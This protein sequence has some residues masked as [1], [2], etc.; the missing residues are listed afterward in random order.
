MPDEASSSWLR[1]SDAMSDRKS[2]ALSTGKE[3]LTKLRSS[4]VSKESEGNLQ[5]RTTQRADNQNVQLI[6]GWT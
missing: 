3:P 2:G 4:K 1:S 6:H 5:A